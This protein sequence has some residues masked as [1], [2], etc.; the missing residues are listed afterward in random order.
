MTQGNSPSAL[1]QRYAKIPEVQLQNKAFIDIRL[2][3]GITKPL[4]THRHM[5]HYGQM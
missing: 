2:R 4:V 5:A 3:P 1:M